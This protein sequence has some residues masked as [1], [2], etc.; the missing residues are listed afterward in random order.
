MAYA[1]FD[2]GATVKQAWGRFQAAAGEALTVGELVD[3][4]FKAAD[5]TAGENPAKYIALEDMASA[6]TGWFALKA[7]LEK[8]STVGTGGAVTAGTHGGT[9]GDILF[10]S[11]TAGDALETP[12]TTGILQVVGQ[13]LTTAAV[14]LD[15]SPE[16]W[17]VCE[18]LTTAKTVDALDI[19]KAM[20]SATT[21][22]VFTLPTTAT[23][24]K[25]TFI[26]VGQD[27]DAE[28]SVSPASTDAISGR[29]TPGVDNKDWINTL[30]TARCMDML[31][32]EYESSTG[33]IITKQIGTWAEET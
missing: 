2:G 15:P 20:C 3:V 8:V 26:N 16:F 11:T 6:D 32:V 30:A 22:V 14:L 17:E 4:D 25:Y 9:A 21:G 24:S 23:G 12:L 31:I 7:V 29:D 33:Y 10:L 13:C 1:H 27:G 5:A 18:V 28:I 19:G